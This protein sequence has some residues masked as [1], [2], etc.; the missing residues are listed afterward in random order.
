MS[1]FG[2]GLAAA[3]GAVAG[4]MAAP[5]VYLDPDM[6]SGIQE[7]NDRTNDSSLV[8]FQA[9]LHQVVKGNHESMTSRIKTTI[10]ENRFENMNSGNPQPVAD[11]SRRELLKRGG[12]VAAAT[13]VAS[14]FSP[15]VLTGKA[16]APK[17]LSFWQFY[18]PATT[19]SSESKWFEDC[20]KGWNATHDVKVE[21][22]F[23]HANE[24]FGGSKLQTAFAS[25]QG[26]DI[27]IISPGDF[28]RFYNGG[29]LVDLT[30][31]MEDAAKKDFFPN[32]MESRIVNEKI[33]FAHRALIV[34]H[35]FLGRSGKLVAATI[36]KHT[37]SPLLLLRNFMR[38]AP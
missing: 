6:M 18:A 2:W 17:T 21:L 24:Y 14:V 9:P 27:F 30:P 36:L 4:M 28:L 1:A 20:V 35:A 23:V 19:L 32:V 26:P 3:I 16:A 37:Q 33:Q 38:K 11:I 31:Y 10:V 25:G 15:F 22:H 8:T 34:G 13:A 29:V 12:K 7:I 5:L